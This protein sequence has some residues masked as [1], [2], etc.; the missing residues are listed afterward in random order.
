[1]RAYFQ[2]DSDSLDIV[3]RHVALSALDAAKIGSIHFNVISKV[4]LADAEGFPIP[5][6]V[7]SDDSP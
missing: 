1:M 3:D 5:T 7:G 2:A 4:L 6:N